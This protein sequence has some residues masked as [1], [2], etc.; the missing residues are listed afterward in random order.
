EGEARKMF[1]AEEGHLWN[2]P[3]LL[4]NWFDAVEYCRWVSATRHIDVRLPTEIEWEKAARGTDGRFHPWG[5]HFDPTFCKMRESRAVY[6]QPEPVGTFEVDASPYGVRDMAGS[7]RE[8]IADIH[9]ELT[10]QTALAEREPSPET[11]RD[12]SSW[13]AIR[14]GNWAAESRL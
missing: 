2:V 8:W 6:P 10:P 3:V 12:E 9:G 14:G 13:R 7:M 1:P 5:D 4:V 11:K